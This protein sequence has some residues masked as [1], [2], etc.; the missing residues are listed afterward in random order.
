MLTRPMKAE[1]LGDENLDKLLFPVIA[2]P[3]FDGIRTLKLD[4]KVLSSTFKPIPNNYIRMLLADQLPD[5]AD[6]E[7]IVGAGFQDCSSGVMSIGGEP[8]FQFWM[9]DLVDPENLDEPYVERLL[10]LHLWKKQSKNSPNVYV[11]PTQFLQNLEELSVF[12]KDMLALGYEGIMTRKPNGGYKCGRST[13]KQQW[14]LKRKPFEDSEARIIGF[15]EQL[16]N[17]NAKTK[18]DLGLTKR[19]SAKAGKVGNGT[20]GKFIAT[21]VHDLFPGIELRIGTGKGLTNELR[22]KVWNNQAGY[23]GKVIKYK[24]QLIGTKDAPR[25]PIFLGFRHPEDITYD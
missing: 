23:L 1:E 10:K 16:T 4:G 8:E 24:F 7:T 25:L 13:L 22:A 9:F 21:D 19:S 6:G 11:V 3:K 14:L 12:E 5:G 2:S 18:N 17:T 15:E 20:L